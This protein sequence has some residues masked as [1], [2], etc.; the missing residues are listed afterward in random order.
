[1][2]SEEIITQVKIK[3]ACIDEILLIMS[4]MDTNSRS[5]NYADKRVK[6]LQSDIKEILQ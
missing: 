3:M 1:M 2:T 4:F 5:F 6:E